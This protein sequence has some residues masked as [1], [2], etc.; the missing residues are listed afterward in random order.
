[1]GKAGVV[2]EPQRDVEGE[3]NERLEI[4]DDWGDNT[5]TFRCQEPPGHAGPHR[6]EFESGGRPV[7][8]TWAS[9][10]TNEPDADE[11]HGRKAP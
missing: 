10:P 11:P 7:T 4:G 3:C 6:E 2:M 5:C 8:V 9:E 1:M